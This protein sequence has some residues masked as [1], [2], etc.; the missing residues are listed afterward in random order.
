MRRR[1]PKQEPVPRVGS[2]V[3]VDFAGR[4]MSGVVLEDR[5][6]VGMGGRRLLRVRLAFSDVDE[7]FELE[8]PL[9]DVKVAA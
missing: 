1:V 8:L 6:P 4:E 7:P 9:A 2:H 5:G 3:T